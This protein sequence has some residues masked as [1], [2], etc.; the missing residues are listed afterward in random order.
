MDLVDPRVEILPGITQGGALNVLQLAVSFPDHRKTV[1][2][3]TYSLL[4]LCQQR[5]MLTEIRRQS[6]TN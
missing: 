3:L 4:L 5:Y 1:P 2:F 6:F